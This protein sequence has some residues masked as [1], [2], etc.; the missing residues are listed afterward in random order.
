MKLTHE[1]CGDTKCLSN[2]MGAVP[3]ANASEEGAIC[4]AILSD[5]FLNVWAFLLAFL[6]NV[7]S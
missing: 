1:A 6:Q 4:N 7:S 2:A 5:F 3:R